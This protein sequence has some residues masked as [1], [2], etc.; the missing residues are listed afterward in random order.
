M[1]V[2][3]SAATAAPTRLFGQH[4][5]SPPAFTSPPQSPAHIDD[6][7]TPELPRDVDMATSSTLPPLDGQNHDREEDALM[8]DSDTLSNGHTDTNTTTT[9]PSQPPIDG[10][11]VQVAAVDDDAMDTSP[12]DSQGLVLPNGSADP[13]EP[14]NNAQSSPTPNGE[15]TEPQEQPT[16]EDVPPPPPLD[17]VT[18][19][20]QTM[21]VA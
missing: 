10:V 6:S 2:T 16:V 8:H 21:S 14:T 18:V 15:N 12:D 5:P 9:D 20:V 13:R 1:S 3:T 7:Q 17:H 19:C 4:S 11:A